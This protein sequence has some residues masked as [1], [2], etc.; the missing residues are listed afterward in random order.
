MDAGENAS[1]A[2]LTAQAFQ[3]ADGTGDWRVIDRDAMAWFPTSSHAAGAALVRRLIDAT[4]TLPDID[5]RA[6]GVQVRLPRGGAWVPETGIPG[7]PAG[8]RF[9]AADLQASR[10]VSTA[11]A[12]LGLTADPSVLQ[13]V[14]I[15][16]DAQDAS[17][18]LPFWSQALGYDHAGAAALHDPGRRRP[19]VR[20]QDQSAPRP[21]RNRL[22]LDAVTTQP[23]AVAT[24]AAAPD[25]GG[26]VQDNGYYATVADADGNEVDVLPLPEGADRWDEPG[27]EDWRLTFAAIA[28]YPTQ[29]QAQAADLVEQVAALA[30]EAGLA[31][32]IDVR[33]DRVTLD[34]GKDLWEMHEGYAPLAARCQSAARTLGLEADVSVLR[35]LQVGIDAVDIPA[36]RRFWTAALGYVEDPRDGVTDIVH[37]HHL[38]MPIFLQRLDAE[39]R[40]RRAQRNRI[41]LDVFV[42]GDEAR[43]RVDAAVAAG[44]RIS[45]DAAAPAWWTITDPEGNEVCICVSPGREEMW[46]T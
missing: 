17:T 36:V 42:P 1:S 44:G 37:P 29:S 38:T 8:G 39:D 16:I 11:A 13:V 22:H 41:H 9:T 31:L 6:G 7:S 25:L 27:T 14:S 18:L 20:F 45:N 40:A 26:R 32:G 30:D 12:D 19:S 43:S 10:A 34:T 35:F 4:T 5:V 2:G 23:V 46:G 24:V 33:G 21:L 15:G 3:A 28:S